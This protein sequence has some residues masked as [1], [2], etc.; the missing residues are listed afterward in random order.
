MEVS[1]APPKPRAT[2]SIVLPHPGKTTQDMEPLR[3]PK[4]KSIKR[5]IAV[6]LAAAVTFGTIGTHQYLENPESFNPTNITRSIT[7]FPGAAWNKIVEISNPSNWFKK[8]VVIV[9]DTFDPTAKKGVIGENNSIK[10][11]PDAAQAEIRE[12]ALSI[13]IIVRLPEGYTKPIN[14]E[15][16]SSV[17]IKKDGEL[18]KDQLILSNLP[19]GTE[20]VSAWK[21]KIN[22]GNWKF[23]TSQDGSQES[24][25]GWI[26]ARDKDGKVFTTILSTGRVKLKKDI[27]YTDGSPRLAD[28]PSAFDADLNP[29]EVIATI[30]STVNNRYFDGQVAISV[31]SYELGGVINLQVQTK[32]G[33]AIILQ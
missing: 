13:P 29:G 12:G 24:L 5:P 23:P 31:T 27:P 26:T 1:I 9:P 30:A 6:G 15:I 2:R 20:I 8:E 22:Q 32:D 17:G 19:I 3:P 4:K 33:K 16:R 7:S 18:I 28:T 14:Y 10:I 11:P 25:Q 21:G